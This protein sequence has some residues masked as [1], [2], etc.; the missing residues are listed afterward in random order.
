MA[1]EFAEPPLVEA[2][3]DRARRAGFP[4]SCDRVVGRL[5]AVLAVPR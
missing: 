5:L 2:A 3:V 1:F 4:F